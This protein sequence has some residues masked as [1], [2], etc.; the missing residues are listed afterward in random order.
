MLNILLVS[1]S[2]LMIGMGAEA[3][4]KSPISLI[5]GAAIGLLMLGSVA[6]AKSNPRAGRIMS[7]VIALVPLGRFLPKFIKEQQMWPAGVTV[8]ASAVV[9]VA[10]IGG[11]VV[12]MKN[13][14]STS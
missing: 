12:G 2:I 7:L 6:L 13:R 5:A 9:I 11:H 4:S 8:I 10:L 3:A 1:F 14:S